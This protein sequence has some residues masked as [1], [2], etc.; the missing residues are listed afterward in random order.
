[1]NNNT[2][3]LDKKFD[4]LLEA[5][6]SLGGEVREI[7]DDLRTKFATKDDLY[8]LEERL[9]REIRAISRAVDKDAETIVDHERRIGTLEKQIA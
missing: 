4:T 2:G 7:R 9:T 6:I 8:D 3:S 5:V 1:M